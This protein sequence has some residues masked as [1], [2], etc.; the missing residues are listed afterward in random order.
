[1]DYDQNA[2]VNQSRLWESVAGTVG[3]R[4]IGAT[5]GDIYSTQR[6]TYGYIFA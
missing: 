4:M 1:M 3:R 2:S 5:H 6:R